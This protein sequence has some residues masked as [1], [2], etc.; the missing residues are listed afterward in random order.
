VGVIFFEHG[1]GAPNCSPLAQSLMISKLR[2]VKIRTQQYTSKH[3]LIAS[4]LQSGFPL[5]CLHENSRTFEKRAQRFT[6]LWRYL[7]NIRSVT[8]Q[9]AVERS[10]QAAQ[11]FS[12]GIRMWSAVSSPSGSGQSVTNKWHLVYFGPEKM[13]LVR[14]IMNV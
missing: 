3:V 7:L 11:K 2:V 4:V 13:L 14:A 6:G 10:S 1:L 9:H 12:Y 5:S 8:E